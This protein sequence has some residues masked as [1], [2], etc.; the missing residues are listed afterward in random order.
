[1]LVSSEHHKAFW[2]NSGVRPE[3]ITVTGQPRFDIYAQRERSPAPPREVP[4]VLFLT[5]DENAYLPIIDRTGL[6]PWRRMRDETEAVLLDVARGG[7][8]RVLFKAHPQPAE[9]QTEHLAELAGNPGVEILDPRGDVRHYILDSDIVVGFQ[10]TALLESLAAGKHTV[11][12]WWT[13]EVERYEGDL[14][15]FHRERGAL[16]VAES[17]R[18]L[19]D[20]IEQGV[21]AAPQDARALV[22]RYL[23]PIDG[24][25]AE[26]SWNELERLVAT[27]DPAQVPGRRQRVAAALTSGGAAAAW[28]VATG[29]APVSYSGYR[30]LRRARGGTVLARSDFEEQLALRRRGAVQRLIAA[31]T[32]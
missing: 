11:Y 12:T 24:K 17:P 9:D 6:A 16:V 5:Y 3:Q 20:A 18:Q 32:R 31:S 29:L 14:I 15:P 1:M 23:G 28:T 13:N 25:A 22:T 27:A 8:A 26:R 21:S 19:Q 30:L 2:V 7:T 10:T 4:T